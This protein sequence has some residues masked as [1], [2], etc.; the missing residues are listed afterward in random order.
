[1]MRAAWFRSLIAVGVSLVASVQAHAQPLFG[2]AESIEST[3]ANADLVVIGKLV[4]FGG[5]EQADEGEKHEATIDV[6]ETLKEDIFAVEPYRRL[7]V[8]V[9]RSASVLANWKD[10][11]HRLLVATNE[12]A[13][14]A[15]TLIEL[16][17]DRPK[18]LTADF[19]LLRDPEAV[20]QAAKE[21]V[22]RMPA[23]VRR[24]HTFGLEVPREGVAG[25][26]WEDAQDGFQGGAYAVFAAS[27]W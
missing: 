5:E 12:C 21:T 13:L 7:R 26:K 11:S 4:G 16:S 22:R 10:R 24:I 9:R 6:E 23:A 25:T 27:R 17:P 3:V 18:V 15:T 1:M 8:D 19:T 2:H 20:I 14:G